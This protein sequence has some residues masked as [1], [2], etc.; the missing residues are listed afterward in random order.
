MP[1]VPR[2]T[3]HEFVTAA[4]GPDLHEKR[5]KSIAA[6]LE[7][8]LTCARFGRRDRACDGGRERPRSE[9]RHQAGGSPSPQQ[10]IFPWDLAEWRVPFVVADRKEIVV[11]F[12]WTDFDDDDQTTITA[13]L[14]EPHKRTTPLI[15][16]TL[17]K[18]KL[19]GQRNDAEDEVL[20][21]VRDVC[22]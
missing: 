22:S 13:H 10:G 6:T 1:I 21:R 2:L 15:W 3:A 9:A 20:A 18:S 16:K 8:A 7:G 19:K 17:R 4:F 14:V 11:A 5:V 12:D